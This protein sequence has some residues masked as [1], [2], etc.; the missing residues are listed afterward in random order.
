MKKNRPTVGSLQTD[1]EEL[2]PRQAALLQL[3]RNL[4]QQRA[5]VVRAYAGQRRSP[6]GAEEVPSPRRDH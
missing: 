3:A 6:A 1:A 5:A 4:G 2:E